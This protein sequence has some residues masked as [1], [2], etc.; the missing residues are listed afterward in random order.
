MPTNRITFYFQDAEGDQISV[1]TY[2]DSTDVTTVAQAQDVV[3]DFE[4][5]IEN[6]IGPVVYAATV[7]FGLTVSSVETPDDG[8]SVYSG[9]TL[10]FKDS[11]TVGQSLYLPGILQS[12][13]ANEIVIP[14]ASPGMLEFLADV[15][16]NGFGTGGHRISSRG[17]GALWNT[18]V[19]GKR[20]TR[21]P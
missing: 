21:K 6:C 14:T 19:I 7:E 15:Q 8:Y 13:I 1:P 10:S 9:A 18:Y 11:D 20:S 2:W 16:T 12:Q 4:A 5:L 3:T 17:S